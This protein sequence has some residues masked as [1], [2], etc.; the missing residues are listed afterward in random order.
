M[1]RP[2]RVLVV[3]D[4]VLIADYVAISLEDAGHEVV[5]ICDCAD[6]ALSLL[7]ETKPDVVVLDIRING[8]VD[9]VD[10]ALRM[11]AEGL[12]TSHLFITGSG[13]PETK[14]RA[15]ATGPIAFLQK[16][17]NVRQLEAILATVRVS[18]SRRC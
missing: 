1:T 14:A 11:Q 3:E 15:L 7:R 13:D 12:A 2:L 5:G 10:L 9:G 6:P 8:H 18:T 4:E 17:V 16:P